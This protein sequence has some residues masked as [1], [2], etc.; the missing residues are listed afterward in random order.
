MAQTVKTIGRW[1]NKLQDNRAEQGITFTIPKVLIEIFTFDSSTQ[2]KQIF[3]KVMLG[4][5]KRNFVSI[6]C[7]V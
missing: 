5:K 2:E 1:P 7:N 4:F 3:V 6:S